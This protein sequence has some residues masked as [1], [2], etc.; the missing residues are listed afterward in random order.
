MKKIL[1]LIVAVISFSA[2]QPTILSDPPRAPGIGE[3]STKPREPYPHCP[4]R[5]PNHP[6][7]ARQPDGSCRYGN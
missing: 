2:C 5:L 3:W 6:P 1:V 4:G 7:M